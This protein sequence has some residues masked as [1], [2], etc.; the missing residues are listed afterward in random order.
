MT[1]AATARAI[2]D[3]EPEPKVPFHCQRCGLVE[4]ADHFGTHPPFCRKVAA[5]AART[6]VMRD[7][8]SPR[9]GETSGRAPF[10]V[11]GGVCRVCSDQ[12]EKDG[13]E[14][15]RQ[16]VCVDC[17]V[18]YGECWFCLDCASARIA[19]FPPDV[20]AKIQRRTTAADARANTK[21]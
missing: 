7:P 15:H 10:L 16:G 17:S 1:E 4:D 13:D 21:K 6:Y 9:G 11:L 12:E 20:Q 8:F 19:E 5:F 2:V 3:Q 18:F 14:V